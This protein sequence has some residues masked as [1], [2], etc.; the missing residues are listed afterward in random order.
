MDDQHDYRGW[1]LWLENGKVGAHII[2]K[3]PE[4]ALKVVTD[5]ATSSRTSGPTSS[6]PTTARR[7]AAGV[8]IYVNGEPQADRRRRPTA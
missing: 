6:S 2:H 4:D 3:W 5:D 8:K 1:D 7:K